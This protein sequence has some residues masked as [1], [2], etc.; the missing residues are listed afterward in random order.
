MRRLSRRS[1]EPRRRTALRNSSSRELDMNLTAA[2]PR[3][4]P[5]PAWIVLTHE[6][7]CS[8]GCKGRSQDARTNRA[9]RLNL[10]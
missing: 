7:R 9:G 1:G 3:C 5:D 2:L 10:E 8:D 4:V 6:S